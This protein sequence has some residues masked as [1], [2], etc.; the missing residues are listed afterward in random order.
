MGYV[1]GTVTLDGEPLPNVVVV[2]KPAEGR[3]AMTQADSKGYYDIE[4]VK[5]EKGT[6][7]GPTTVS[8]EWLPG[9][10]DTK[11]IPRKAASGSSEIQIEVK[12]GKQTQNFDLTTDAGAPKRPATVSD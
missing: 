8:F 2:M 1:S 10:S 9:Q 5:G 6:K 7:V 3:P 11:P 12:P 4:Y